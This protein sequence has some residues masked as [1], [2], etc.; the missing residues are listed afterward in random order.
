M[1][2]E[3]FSQWTGGVQSIAAAIALVVGGMWSYLLFV[4]NRLGRPC[5]TAAH[6]VTVKDLGGEGLLVHVA[7]QLTNES[8]VLAMVISGEVRF[9]RL[10]P[11]DAK[12]VP[13]LGEFR[14]PERSGEQE[15][16]WPGRLVYSFDWT[17]EPREIEPRESDTFHFDFVTSGPLE[18]F[19][20]YSYFENPTKRERGI[21]WCTTTIHDM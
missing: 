19:E 13:M 5:L 20:V 7:V 11:L 12:T 4:R 17:K 2:A 14:Q 10:L 16:C 3:A 8:V 18:T 1:T 9:V 21:G 15:V 6:T